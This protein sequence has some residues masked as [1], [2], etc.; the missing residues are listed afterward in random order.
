MM[1]RDGPGMGVLTKYLL[2]GYDNVMKSGGISDHLDETIKIE[3]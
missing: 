2:T 1:F 3:R